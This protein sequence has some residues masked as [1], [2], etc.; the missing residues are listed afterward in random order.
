MHDVTKAR[1][2]SAVAA[3]REKLGD[4]LQPRIEIRNVSRG[5]AALSWRSWLKLPIKD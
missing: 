5:F 3:A 2:D 4:P 1:R